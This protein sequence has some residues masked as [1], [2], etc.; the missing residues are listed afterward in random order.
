MIRRWRLIAVAATLLL[1]G[2]D[3]EDAVHGVGTLERDRIELAADSGEPIVARLAEEGDRVAVGDTLLRQD[4]ALAETALAGARAR[5]GEA[6]AALAEAEA[7]P[8]SQTVLM[9]EARLA[10]AASAE[11]T[12]AAELR[13]EQALV[14]QNFAS[15]NLV[16]VLQGRFEE[17][18][19]SRREAAAALDELRA[20]TRREV[21]DRARE[22]LAAAEA[23]ARRAAIALARTDVK[24]PVEATVEALP[25]ET[26]ERP[27]AGQ[28]LAVL[29]AAGPPYVRIYVPEPVRTRVAL[30]DPAEVR[31]DGRDTVYRGRIRWIATEASFTPYFALTQR[32]R[33]RLSYLAEIVLEDAAGLPS[34]VPVRVWFPGAAAP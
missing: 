6:A 7:G 15:A 20:G 25:L 4:P 13:R 12:A 28:T 34:G 3:V 31:I 9:A 30:G 26:G 33:S 16:D 21:L 5:R 1:A 19:A 10:A 29:R 17:A 32:D 11:R 2:C 22:T 18:A 14:A 27:R 23:D 24:A 8:R